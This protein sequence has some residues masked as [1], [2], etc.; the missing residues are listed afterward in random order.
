MVVGSRPPVPEVTVRQGIGRGR[1]GDRYA[2][3]DVPNRLAKRLALLAMCLGQFMAML[4]NTIV[5]VALPSIQARFGASVS[6]LEWVVTANT[7][8]FACLLRG[9]AAANPSAS[10]GRSGNCVTPCSPRRLIRA[11]RRP[12]WVARTGRGCSR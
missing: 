6:G 4:D 3:G 7:S 5:N 2:V 8:P 10:T 1:A 12:I 9:R 11:S